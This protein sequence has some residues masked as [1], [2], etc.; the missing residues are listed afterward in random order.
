MI[1]ITRKLYIGLQLNLGL[2]REEESLVGLQDFLNNDLVFIHT[3]ARTSEEVF[4]QVAAK[5]MSMDM[6]TDA[7]L[8]KVTEREKNFPTGIETERFGVAIPH[9]NPEYVKKQFIAVVTS[10]EGVPFSRMDDT[11]AQ[12][13][14][15]AIFVLG[16]N[17]PHTQLESLQA[18]MAVLQNDD[19]IQQILD[20]TDVEQVIQSILA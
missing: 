2:S 8:E 19:K 16:L 13:K 20:S 1:D 12:I 14:A 4:K 7:F 5:A 9:T 3:S 18:I 11:N 17:E 15:K 10:Q 6:I